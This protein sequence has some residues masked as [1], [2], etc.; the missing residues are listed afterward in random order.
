MLCEAIHVV[1]ADFSKKVVA[2]VDGQLEGN[3]R[4]IKMVS[5]TGN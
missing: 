1:D 3:C 4:E 5:S 2:S